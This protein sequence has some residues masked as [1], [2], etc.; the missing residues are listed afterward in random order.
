MTITFEVVLGICLLLIGRRAFWLLV[1]VCGFLLGSVAISTLWIESP[2]WLTLTVGIIAGVCGAILVIFLQKLTVALS[3]FMSAIW[4]V[5]TLK[6]HAPI[7]WQQPVYIIIAMLVTGILGALLVSFIFE[8]A[9]VILSSILGSIL[10]V[11]ALGT[12]YSEWIQGLS[13]VALTLSGI[14]IQGF[15]K[16][17]SD[18]KKTPKDKESSPNKK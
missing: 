10:V 1:G 13:F 9:L 17:V 7:E 4:V 12:E 2:E 14:F 3:G 8:W 6:D 18:K 5:Y 16:K 11:Q 15:D